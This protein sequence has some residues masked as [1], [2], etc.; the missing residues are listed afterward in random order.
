MSDGVFR[1]DEIYRFIK[2]LYVEDNARWRKLGPTGQRF[3][4]QGFHDAL[5]AVFS[6][7]CIQD[8]NNLDPEAWED[9]HYSVDPDTG[10][11]WHHI[12]DDGIPLDWPTSP[13]D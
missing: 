7:F 10:A 5:A 9:Y 3:Y 6:Q 4:R 2:A 8:A 1:R 11:E 13:Q 12:D